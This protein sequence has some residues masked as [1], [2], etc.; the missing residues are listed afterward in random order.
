MP[1]IDLERYPRIRQ[2]HPIGCIPVNIE[3]A[4]KYFGEDNYD[5]YY[6]LAFFGSRRMPPNFDQA[7][8][9]FNSLIRNF[10][11]VFK[12]INDFD[13]SINN[14]I[15]Y[16]KENI[17]NQIPVLVSFEASGGAHIRTLIEYNDTEFI[18]FDPGDC[19]IKRFNYLTD[20]FKDALRID[21]HTLVIKPR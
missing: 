21:Y 17:D 20:Q 11:F 3:N 12:G 5:E 1:T 8:P 18:F 19:Q 14:M 2:I 9:I 13:N 6:F 4:L 15:E 10:E 7:T 16:L